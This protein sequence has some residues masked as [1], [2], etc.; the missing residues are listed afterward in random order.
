MTKPFTWSHT[1]LKE[2]ELCPR[3]YHVNRVLKLYPYQETE[4]T[5]EG[6]IF[7]K[8]ME[9]AVRD[10]TPLPKKYEKHQALLDAM[11]AK[12]GRKQAEIKMAATR[13]LHACDYFDKGVWVRGVADLL[14]VDD[15]GLK[16]WVV[17]W[18]T[19]KNKYP[20]LDQLVLMSLLV[21]AKYPHIR[22]VNSALVFVNYDDIRTKKMA[23]DEAEKEW[24]KYRERTGKIEAAMAADTWNPS[25]GP[26]C[27]WC[28][29]K[30]C[31]HHPKH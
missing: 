27:G 10:N 13:E 11:L 8:A 12:P 17:D 9:D 29:H 20:D 5:K 18:K 22:Q 7:H 16:A 25:Q 23:R 1:A 14:I 26:L 19:G 15:E 24:W 31:E 6:N 4:A 28:E 3:K 30:A 21:F 2:F